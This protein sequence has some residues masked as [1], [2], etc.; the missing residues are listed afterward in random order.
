MSW[1]KKIGIKTDKQA[2][3]EEHKHFPDKPILAEK[4]GQ[5]LGLAKDW[6]QKKN[7]H[8]GIKNAVGENENQKNP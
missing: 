1:S 4:W 8:E 5:G 2:T 6:S 3:H 7:D